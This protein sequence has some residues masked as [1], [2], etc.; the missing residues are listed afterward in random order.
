MHSYGVSTN[1]IA[2]GRALLEE[3]RMAH[4]LCITNLVVESDS[5]VMV[6]WLKSSACNFWYLRD[7]LEEIQSL[8]RLLNNRICCIYGE[9]NMVADF[10]SKGMY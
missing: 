7:F 9:A 1:M 10:F 8:L 3:L 6:G 2:E 4:Q 5:K